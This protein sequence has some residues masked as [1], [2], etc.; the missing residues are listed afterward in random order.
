VGEQANDPLRMYLSDITTIS[1]NLAGI[2]G[3]SVPCGFT[4]ASASQPRLPVGLQLLGKPFG[5][6]TILRIG[7]AYEQATPWHDETPPLVSQ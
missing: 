1:C 2:C 5:E 6:Q 4:P 3:L 7:H